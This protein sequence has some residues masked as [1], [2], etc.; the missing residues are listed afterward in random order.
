MQQHTRTIHGGDAP[1]LLYLLVNIVMMRLKSLVCLLGISLC[2]SGVLAQ[3]AARCNYARFLERKFQENPNLRQYH[4]DMRQYLRQPQ[5]AAVAKNSQAVVTIPVVF[6][7]LYKNA[8]QNVSDAQ[9]D[10]QLAVLNADYRKLNADFSSVVPAA[11]QN[12]GADVEMVFC[13]AVRT[14]NGTATSGVVRKAIPETSVFED[15]YFTSAGDLAW[16]TTKYLNIW[17]GSFTDTTLL[18]FAYPPSMVGDPSDGLCIGYSNFGT[19]GTATAPYNKGRTATH[20]IGHYFGLEHPW[21]EDNSACGSAANDDGCADTPATFDPYYNCPTF[22][23]NTNACTST[24][25]GSMFMNYMDYVYDNCMALFT[26]NQKTIM[27]NAINGP[28]AALLNSNACVPL[29]VDAIEARQ[30]I[31]AFPNP[32][33]QSFTLSS[34]RMHISSVDVY[35]LMGQ[36]IKT[37]S[38]TSDWQRIDFEELASGTYVLRVYQE[39][40]CVTSLKVVKK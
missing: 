10:S 6:H 23:D 3:P 27:R 37:I 9:I 29:D 17:V 14:P 11:F 35:N 16:D 2:T 32:F 30:A 28:R 21:G 33:S 26:L 40:T 36:H 1:I 31:Q 25:N 15:M 22:P 13:K 19:T 12:V 38:L 18:G 20:E 7:I 34:P 4:Q 24:P 8:N 5:S 39:N